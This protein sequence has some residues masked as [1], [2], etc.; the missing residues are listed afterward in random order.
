MA[1]GHPAPLGDV[2]SLFGSPPELLFGPNL[3]RDPSTHTWKMFSPKSGLDTYC[4]SGWLGTKKA[5]SFIQELLRYTGGRGGVDFPAPGQ[6]ALRG[7]GREGSANALPRPL[8][9]CEAT[10]MHMGVCIPEC[11]EGPAVNTQVHMN[12]NAWPQTSFFFFFT[13]HGCSGARRSKRGKI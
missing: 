6:K 8:Q 12:L 11:E 1:S 9:V 13:N 10:S 7:E 3:A 4:S 5:H 2:C